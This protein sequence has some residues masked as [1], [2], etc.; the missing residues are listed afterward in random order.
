MN[1]DNDAVVSARIVIRSLRQLK[2][3]GRTRSLKLLE[4]REPDLAEYVLEELSAIHGKLV[5]LGGPVRDTQRVY[6]QMQSLVL[7]TIECLRRGNQQH[8]DRD[9]PQ[10]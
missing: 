7:L 4:H 6:L 8:E 5:A 2:L 10:P 9:R 1:R 3:L